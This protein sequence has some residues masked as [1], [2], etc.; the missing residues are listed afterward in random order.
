MDG[1]KILSMSVENFCF[2]DS[3]NFMPK[4]LKNM[5]KPF[6]LTS[7]KGYYP[8]FFNRAKNLDYV[9]LYPEPKYY[10]ADFMSADDRAQFLA[11]YEEQKDKMFHNKEELL[12]YCIDY[13]SVLRQACWTFR[14]LFLK[15][16]KWTFQTGFN[17][18][19]YL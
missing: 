17:N 15:L 8:H 19:V 10:G 3:L 6:D 9:G 5:P 11:W 1:T 13:V 16:V 4:R 14:Y 12:A 2:L 7:K 18:I